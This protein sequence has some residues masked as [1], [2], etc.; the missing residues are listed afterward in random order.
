MEVNRLNNHIELSRIHAEKFFTHSLHLY[1]L[2]NNQVR[3]NCQLF[4][5]T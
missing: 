5:L 4:W 3:K 1:Q 2:S